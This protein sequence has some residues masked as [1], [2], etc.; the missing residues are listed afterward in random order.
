MLTFVS[1]DIVIEKLNRYFTLQNLPLKCNEDGICNGLAYV[2]A[3]YVLIGEEEKFHRILK[4]IAGGNV[5]QS[6]QPGEFELFITHVL[7]SFLPEKYNKELSQAMSIK[8]FG[9]SETVFELG[10][11]LNDNQWQSVIKDID[12]KDDEVMLVNSI[13]HTIAV[14]RKKGKYIVYDPNYLLGFHPVRSEQT[15]IRELHKNV[16]AYEG[17]ELGLRINIVKTKSN[18]ASLTKRNALSFY[19]QYV[20]KENINHIATTGETT[21]KTLL[22]AIE[23]NDE[24]SV[25]Y[26]LSLGAKIDDR[27][28]AKAIVGN[29]AKVLQQLIQ[30]K[31][32]K[33]ETVNNSIIAAIEEGRLEAFNALMTHD[34]FKNQFETLF[35]NT[36]KP[37][38]IKLAA[39][40]G[41]LQLLQL[42]IEK[43]KE[44]KRDYHDIKS[45]MTRNDHCQQALIGAINGG[46]VDCIKYLIHTLKSHQIEISDA[47]KMNAFMHALKSNQLYVCSTL[48]SELPPENLMHIQMS[49]S[50]VEKTNVCIL[51]ELKENG[52]VFSEKAE[53]IIAKKEQRAIGILL[54][55]GIELEKFFEYLTKKQDITVSDNTR[56]FKET[57]NK[58]KEADWRCCINKKMS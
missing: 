23:C 28:I 16:F 15:L 18:E 21:T 47:D 36:N 9:R 7:L 55:M 40:G 43:C 37:M 52:V 44:N 2:Y 33:D 5:D 48:L 1:Q 17:K 46:S 12:L 8:A 3:Q 26:L 19:Q 13:N 39:K 41:N 54:L 14:S 57:L 50:M 45:A 22:L 49:L 25:L 42:I 20:S 58:L 31:S 38:L 51:N 35:L 29:H 34:R 56:K 24:D 11:V 53:A 4:A 32:I 27:A 30:D 6:L 10:M